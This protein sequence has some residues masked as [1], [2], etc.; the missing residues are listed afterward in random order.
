MWLAGSC[1]RRGDRIA[2]GAGPLRGHSRACVSLFPS[3]RTPL[4][5]QQEG[6]GRTPKHK[7][8]GGSR[9]SP[10]RLQYFGSRWVRGS[11]LSG[12][13]SGPK[14]VWHLAPRP[15]RGQE[16]N[17][18]EMGCRARPR[19]WK[20]TGRHLDSTSWTRA[21]RPAPRRED[22]ARHLWRA[23]ASSGLYPQLLLAPGTHLLSV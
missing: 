16:D 10:E 19:S 11:R 1:H 12:R 3:S 22:Q 8:D 17:C 20:E 23:C 13:G 6:H 7:G 21:P 15:M 4:K 9:S 5:W 2:Q 14:R 18:P